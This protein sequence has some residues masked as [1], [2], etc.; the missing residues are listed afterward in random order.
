M[1]QLSYRSTRGSETSVTA[2]EAIL[3]GIA[4]DGGLYVP[5][6][7]PKL[8]VPLEALAKL[9][10][11]DLA[12]EILH[13]FLTDYEEEDLRLA[14]ARAYDEKFTTAEIAPLVQ[15]AGVHFLELFHGPT[16]AFKDMALS[17][18]PH[19]LKIAVQKT[20]LGKDVVIL[21]ATSGDTGKAA[22]EGFADV[23][24][25]RII[26]FFPEHGV[27]RVQ[28]QQ[29]VT[30]VGENTYVVGIEGN[31]DDAQSGVKAMFTNTELIAAMDKSGFAFSS[32]NSI[33]IGR[34]A[35]QIIYY[36]YAYLTMLSTGEISA[37]DAVN[38]S[39]P[40]GN[41]GN[42]LAGYYAKQMGLPIN[43]LLCASNK[44]N[45]L[46]D[47]LTT[48]TYDRSREFFV[49][50]S[51]SMDILI[52]SNLERLLYHISGE[53]PSVVPMLMGQLASN[54]QYTLPEA[55]RKNLTDFV[56]GYA[57]EKETAEAIRAVF[58][59]SDYL[60]DPHTAVAYAVWQ[61]YQ[62]ETGDK[63][64]TVVVSTASPYKFSKD[65]LTSIDARY[66]KYDDF[67]LFQEVDKLSVGN[68]PPAVKDLDAREILHKRVCQ[69]EEMRAVVEDIL[70]L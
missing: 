17:I 67:A 41:F 4:A 54:G 8:E 38:F 22:L 68:I 33:N 20:D 65:V 12:F 70:G 21:T 60:I 19:L 46:F 34:L 14:I 7:I 30:Q 28:K 5:Q 6:N 53:N 37:G 40:T 23:A 11:Q 1:T 16:L 32:A 45:V 51:P 15:K 52:S 59:T 13:L 62:K 63:T 57:T 58:A 56:G 27:S 66:A 55:M 50:M 49:T 44:N 61:Q 10:Y 3:Q 9:S 31:F 48:G 64:P 43:K 39:V 24:G 47:F 35:P 18:L 25:T 42:I 69:K 2:A 26:V 29:M 36:F